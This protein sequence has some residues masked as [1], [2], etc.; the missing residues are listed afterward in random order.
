M[1][2]KNNIDW[3]NLPLG[4]YP[5]SWF[6]SWLGVSG[7]TV[8]RYRKKYKRPVAANW[9]VMTFQESSLLQGRWDLYLGSV[10]NQHY[11]RNNPPPRIS[12]PKPSPIIKALPSKPKS[13]RFNPSKAL[14]LIENQVE[15]LRNQ[16]ATQ[17]AVGEKYRELAAFLGILES[18]HEQTLSKARQLLAAKKDAEG[19]IAV[20]KNTFGSL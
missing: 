12:K 13:V 19:K 1:N 8:G 15:D 11:L 17:L 16:L 3:K 4:Q 7:W 14:D 10:K 2:N 20:L 5:D 9:K 18:T 6:A